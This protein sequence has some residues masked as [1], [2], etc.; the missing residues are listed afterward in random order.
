MASSAR[1]SSSGLAASNGT[2][3]TSSSRAA[4]ASWARVEMVVGSTTTRDPPRLRDELEKNFEPLHVQLRGEN[5]HPGGIAAR[6][7]QA[8]RKSTAHHVIGNDARAVILWGDFHV[9]VD[10]GSNRGAY[11]GGEISRL[12]GAFFQR[13]T[14]AY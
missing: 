1:S 11:Q 3:S 2:S 8:G 13:A 6:S 5:T 12:F 10:G 14:A 9:E 7:H 4:L